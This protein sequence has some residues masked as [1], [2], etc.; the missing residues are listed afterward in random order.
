MNYSYWKVVMYRDAGSNL[1]MVRPSLMS[2]VKLGLTV[3][4]I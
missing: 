2:M 4:R 1:R 3:S